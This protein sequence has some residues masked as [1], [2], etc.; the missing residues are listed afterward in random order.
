MNCPKAKPSINR[1]RE[2]PATVAV[3]ASASGNST[4]VGADKSIESAGRAAKSPSRTVNEKL[5]GAIRINSS[6]QRGPCLR[7]RRGRGSYRLINE[8]GCAG[9]AGRAAL[10]RPSRGE[11]D[12]TCDRLDENDGV[13]SARKHPQVVSS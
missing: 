11:R 5:S 6:L 8:S 12:G 2:S 9:A 4:R 7:C 1:E 3:V 13:L 10:I